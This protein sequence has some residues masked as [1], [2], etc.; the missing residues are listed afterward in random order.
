MDKQMLIYSHN[1]VL[2]SNK[3][4]PRTDTGENMNES[5]KQYTEQKKTGIKEHILFAYI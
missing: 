4:E 5:Q 3:N 1:R 2:F